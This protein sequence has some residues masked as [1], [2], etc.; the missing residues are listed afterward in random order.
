MRIMPFLVNTQQT[1]RKNSATVQFTGNA[2]GYPNNLEGKKICWDGSLEADEKEQETGMAGPFH[3]DKDSYAPQA[4]GRIP[5]RKNFERPLDI[6][7]IGASATS[8]DSKKNISAQYF[9][10]VE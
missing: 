1:N 8:G 10:V 2:W 5:I 9:D 7:D 3:V 4:D 6:T